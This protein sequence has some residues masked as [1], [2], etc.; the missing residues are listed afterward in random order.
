[1]V[2]SASINGDDALEI[3]GEAISDIITVGRVVAKHNENMRTLFELDD[4]TGVFTV[5]FYQKGEGEEPQALR[6]FNYVEGMY[7]RIYGSL[8]VFKEEKALVGTNIQA[9]TNH[10]EVTNHFLKVF[11]AHCVRKHGTLGNQELRAGKDG[12][13]ARG[14]GAM[15]GPAKGAAAGVDLQQMV[16]DV[17]RELKKQYSSQFVNKNDVWTSCQNKMSHAEFDQ[18]LSALEDEGAI[19]QA[20][21][22]ETFCLTDD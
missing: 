15:G 9:I 1:M 2:N 13:Q 12:Q 3:D 21:S 22:A 7:A 10:S 5:I 8:R 19:Y 14:A 4:G 20:G 6:N 16:L 17:M 18:H 11:T